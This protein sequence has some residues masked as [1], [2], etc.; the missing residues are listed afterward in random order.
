M[1]SFAASLAWLGKDRGLARSVT[2][3]TGDDGSIVSV[4]PG[5]EMRSST[6]ETIIVPGFVNAHS[7]CFHR[8]IRG[9]SE[10]RGG[11]FWA[12]R[13]LM[14]GVAARLTPQSYRE[15]ATY[16]YAE[17]LLSG[18]TTVGEFHYL[19]HGE[20]GR[21]YD[22]PNEMGLALAEA[23]ASAGIRLTLIDAC[24]LQAGV[25]G[26]PLQG[27]Q[28]R[29]G[30]GSGEAWSSRVAKL[31][32]TGVF[33]NAEDDFRGPLDRPRLGVAIHSVRAVPLAAMGTV[34]AL[35]RTNDWPLHV[36]L[37]E[38]RAENEACLKETGLTPTDL[39]GTAGAWSR[40]ATAVHATHLSAGD[41]S[42][43]GLAGTAVC[44][45]GTTERDLGDGVG[46]FTELTE[47][48]CSLCVGSDS[49]AVI[50]PFEETRSLE[51]N[52]RL[53]HERRGL[54]SATELL[55]AGTVGGA[56]ALGWP[57]IGLA[58]GGLGDFVSIRTGSL[59]LAGT[60]ATAP[61]ADES[62]VAAAVVF[63]A[64]SRDVDTVVVGGRRLV[65]GGEHV[66]LGPPRAIAERLDNAVTKLLGD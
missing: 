6:D 50:D 2:I 30:D 22:D 60:R 26:A 56:A 20:D 10:T 14:F 36:H 5:G 9:R 55:A 12:W 32:G 19:H 65:E 21:P 24:Y 38:Q 59:G 41:I 52:Q 8:A 18:F 40:S 25:D 62:T 4:S 45:C 48:G 58:A 49:H 47:A 34:V 57:D 7:H 16:V 3:G 44:A 1:A 31:A 35:S 15:L 66:T 53:T 63:A 33:G 23:A 29:F 13:D 37:S 17:M 64:G 11:D 61:D 51:L 43:L 27:T 42:R 46:S 39:L 54:T 28:L